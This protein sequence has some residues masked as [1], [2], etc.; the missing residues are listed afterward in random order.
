MSAALEGD[1]GQMPPDAI[2]RCSAEDLR[3]ALLPACKAALSAE[4]FARDVALEVERLLVESGVLRRGPS[5]PQLPGVLGAER[6]LKTT[7]IE[8]ALEACRQE[9]GAAR[10]LA[11]LLWVGADRAEKLDGGSDH[12]VAEVTS[13]FVEMAI[14]S[15]IGPGVVLNAAAAIVG[16]DDE[17]RASSH[18]SD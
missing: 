5:A 2:L 1:Q 9:T 17:T 3:R 13:R 18:D 11:H 10:A 8:A 6:P 16:E 12:V 14:S 15:G 4:R 7:A